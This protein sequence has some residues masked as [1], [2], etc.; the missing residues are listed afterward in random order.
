MLHRL[1]GNQP[2]D[3]LK[4]QNLTTITTPAYLPGLFA[5]L[6]GITDKNCY[7]FK[8]YNLLF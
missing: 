6:L 7:V 4:D 8:V 2:L 1:E 3:N 5:A